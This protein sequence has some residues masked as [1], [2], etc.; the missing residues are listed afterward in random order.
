MRVTVLIAALQEALD[1]LGPDCQV[2]TETGKI[3][4]VMLDEDFNT[5]TLTG[6]PPEQAAEAK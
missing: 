3:T 6:S 5:V 1:L 2:W 4:E